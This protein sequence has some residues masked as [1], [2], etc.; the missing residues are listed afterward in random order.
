MRHH[1][2]RPQAMFNKGSLFYSHCAH[3][4]SVAARRM[5]TTKNFEILGIDFIASDIL[6]D[7]WIVLPVIKFYNLFSLRPY[8]KYCGRQK[9]AKEFGR[10]RHKNKTENGFI[11]TFNHQMSQPWKVSLKAYNSKRDTLSTSRFPFIIRHIM[12]RNLLTQNRNWFW[13]AR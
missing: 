13:I 7:P 8:G 1:F 3:N 5:T 11:W 2:R 6:M 9:T 12:L 4:F 10:F